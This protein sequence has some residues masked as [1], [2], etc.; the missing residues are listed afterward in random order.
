M[1]KGWNR[2]SP[3]QIFALATLSLETL[4]KINQEWK[5][6]SERALVWLVKVFSSTMGKREIAEGGMGVFIPP[7]TENY[8]LVKGYLETLVYVRIP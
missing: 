2:S 8:P 6:G 4:K 3:A 1:L 7:Y 5:C